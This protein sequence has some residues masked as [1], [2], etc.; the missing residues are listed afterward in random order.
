MHL[1]TYVIL[2]PENSF[3]LNE[4]KLIVRKQQSALDSL[5]NAFHA[6]IDNTV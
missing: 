6:Y 3:I 2:C 4:L 5:N 1:Y